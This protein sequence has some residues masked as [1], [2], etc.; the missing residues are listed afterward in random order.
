MTITSNVTVDGVGLYASN[1]RESAFLRAS[2]SYAA[3]VDP[4]LPNIAY[5]A[6][7]LTGWA[8]AKI[9]VSDISLFPVPPSGNVGVVRIKAEVI[10]YSNV[11][12]SNST[13]GTL[14]RNVGNT[15]FSTIS[16]NVATGSL[17]SI[18]GLRSVSS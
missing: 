9:V 2:P 15:P 17:I 3:N 14:T 12:S 5:T 4:R 8:N 18:L 11:W 7:V 16:G 6:D 1:T 10:W 13:L